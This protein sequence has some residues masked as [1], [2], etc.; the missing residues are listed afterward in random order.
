MPLLTTIPNFPFPNDQMIVAPFAANVNPNAIGVVRYAYI[1]D[2]SSTRDIST[3]IRSNTVD[4]Y[5][6]GGSMLVVE[7]AFVPREGA[8]MVSPVI[9]APEGNLYSLQNGKVCNFLYNY[10]YASPLSLENVYA[11]NFNA[12]SL[13]RK[14]EVSYT[15]NVCRN[16]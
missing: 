8:S 3:F 6:S 7:W 13:L 16:C 9:F 14:C 15:G 2:Y 11:N 1:D 12:L 5:Y 10:M 4:D